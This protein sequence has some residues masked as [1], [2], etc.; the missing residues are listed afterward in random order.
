VLFRKPNPEIF[1]EAHNSIGYVGF[2]PGTHSGSGAVG[3]L[4]MALQSRRG[5]FKSCDARSL[6]K[7][8]ADSPSLNTAIYDFDLIIPELCFR[9]SFSAV[10]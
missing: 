3:G 10:S 5:E 2:S 9:L 7:T 6:G 8:A 4:S 1:A